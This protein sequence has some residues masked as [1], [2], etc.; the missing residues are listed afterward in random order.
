MKKYILLPLAIMVLVA[1]AANQ[2]QR[3]TA[4][5]VEEH[6]AWLPVANEYFGLT[7]ET[8]NQAG[9]SK[10]T[11]TEYGVLL[12]AIGTQR[13]QAAENAKKNVLTYDCGGLP[14]K[15]S[16]IKIVVDSDS[17][18]LSEIMSP[19]R[20][21]IRG[22]ADV[23]IV[24]DPQQADFGVTILPMAL[25]NV[26]HYKAGYAA[27]IITY[28]T[29]QARLGDTKWPLKIINNHWVFT[30]GDA[31]QIV[32]D[33]VTSID[34]GDIEQARKIHAAVNSQAK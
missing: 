20:Q 15:N 4:K 33:I 29:C 5:P 27:S 18:A 28:G 30:A 31:S 16:K 7:Q 6:A 10:L 3:K 14:E 1:A 23:E 13:A 32:N 9:L 34:T 12:T 21:R 19:L 25:Y 8:F 11:T 24:F 22:M 26:N 2:V 17:D